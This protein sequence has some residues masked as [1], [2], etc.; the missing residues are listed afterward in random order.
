MSEMLE[1]DALDLLIV[2]AGPA[3]LA[4]GCAAQDAGLTFV[5]VE[6]HGLVQSLVEHPQQIRYFSPA[7][8]L[9]IGG[10]PF[11]VAGGHKPTR[12]D[13]LAYYR[14]VAAAR[15]LPLAT[16]EEVT[17]V[18]QAGPAPPDGG[19]HIRSVRRV[20]GDGEV[21]ERRARFLLVC[22]GTF[23]NPRSLDVPGGALPKVFLKLDDP[24]PFFGRDVLVYGGGNSAAT[25]AMTLAEAGARVTI[26]MRRPPTDFQSHLRP[27]IVRDLNI[28]AD[29]KRLTLISDVRLRKV[30]PDCVELV[31]VEYGQEPSPDAETIVLPNDFVFALIGQTADVGLFAHLGVPLSPDGLPEYD[32]KTAETAVPGLYVAGSLSRANIILESR[33]RA[34]EIVAEVVERLKEPVAERFVDKV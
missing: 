30:E 23:Q 26:A 17:D 34:V 19:F 13:A 15:R 11:P 22:A 24:T 4:A 31:H 27:F 12:E 2:G 20:A 5:I 1:V 3:G 32:E 8:E 7:D 33:R 9:A 6:R 10:V 29:E 25:A 14:A 18:R 28:M 21:V 16:W